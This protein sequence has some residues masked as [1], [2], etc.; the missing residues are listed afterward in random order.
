MCVAAAGAACAVAAASP[1]AASAGPLAL[2]AQGNGGT[3]VSTDR[4]CYVVGQSVQLTGSGFEP[5]RTFVVSIDGVYLGQ[6]TTDSTGSFSVPL[7]PGGLPAGAAQHLDN[8]QATDGTM[9]A[10]TAFMLTRSAGALITNTSGGPGSLS[11]RFLVWGFSLT[12][13]ARP[14]YVHYVGPSGK[15][16]KTVALGNTGGQCGYLRTGR[17]RVFPFSV[18]RGTWT[19]QVDA[20]RS[21]SRTTP[22]PRV[23]I[24]VAIG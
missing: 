23:R 18:T 16:R 3:S 7:H 10:Q 6:R 8:L 12:G 1:A 4:G 15:L 2:A 5:G 9:S 24:R 20:I 21:Y 22:G 11:G 13:A 17:R 14:I 19:V